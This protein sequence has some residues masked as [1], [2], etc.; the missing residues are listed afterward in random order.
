MTEKQLA[1]LQEWVRCEIATQ[2]SEAIDSLKGQESTSYRRRDQAETSL[3][4][5]FAVPK[6]ES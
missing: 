3:R 6:G 5:A 1:A 2:I 4:E